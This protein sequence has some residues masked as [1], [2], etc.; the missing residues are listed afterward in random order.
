MLNSLNSFGSCLG[1]ASCNGFNLFFLI[2]GSSL[3]S[4]KSLANIF[5]KLSIEG[6]LLNSFNDNI[7]LYTFEL[8]SGLI[9]LGKT[10]VNIGINLSW[11]FKNCSLEIDIICKNLFCSSHAFWNPSHTSFKSFIWSSFN[12]SDI[13]KINANVQL[14]ASLNI[15]SF[16]CVYNLYSSSKPLV[17]I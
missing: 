3:T 2:Y 4:S 7:D 9:L 8:S 6:V 12:E 1:N 15:F 13:E 5:L 10:P 16:H 14:N 17:N 11:S